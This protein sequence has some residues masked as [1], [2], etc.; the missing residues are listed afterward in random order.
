MRSIEGLDGFNIEPLNEEFFKNKNSK[1]LDI[2]ISKLE[3]FTVVLRTKG[4]VDQNFLKMFDFGCW[5]N[6][7]DK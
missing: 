7:K 5:F 6:R 3:S 2:R 4:G 1:V